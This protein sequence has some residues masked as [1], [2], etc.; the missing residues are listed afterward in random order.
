MLREAPAHA[1]LR[2][3]KAQM[4][5]RTGDTAEAKRLLREVVSDAPNFPRALNSLARLWLPGPDYRQVLRRIHDRLRPRTYL[6]IGVRHGWT[7]RLAVH[8]DMI[9]GIDPEPRPWLPMPRGTR[10]FRERSDDFFDQHSRESVLGD[11]VVDLAFID[12]MHLFEFGVRDFGN[13]ERWCSPRSTVVLHDCLSVA[14]ISAARDRQ[15]GFW[16]GDTWKALECLLSHRADLKIAVVPCFPSGLVVVQNLD[17]ASD[18]LKEALSEVQQAYTSKSYPYEPGQWP[19]QY[20]I[21]ENSD[22]GLAAALSH[23]PSDEVGMAP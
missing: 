7:L 19:S 3:H 14:P 13:V 5:A 10:L 11:R 22:A 15:V 21:V 4:L 23:S 2:F 6:E 17:P 16:V 20:G 8:S 18:V 12:G 9:V 1:G